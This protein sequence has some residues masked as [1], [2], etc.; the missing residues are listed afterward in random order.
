MKKSVKTWS[1]NGVVIAEL[2]EGKPE[3]C[4]RHDGSTYTAYRFHPGEDT[5]WHS[6]YYMAV[7]YD[8]HIEPHEDQKQT[9][10]ISFSAY[11]KDHEEAEEYL[12]THEYYRNVHATLS[13]SECVA[14]ADA[15]HWRR[16][17]RGR[18][19]IIKPKSRARLMRIGKKYQSR[20]YQNRRANRYI[21]GCVYYLI[22]D[23]DLVDGI[24]MQDLLHLNRLKYI[25][26]WLMDVAKYDKY[27][28]MADLKADAIKRRLSASEALYSITNHPHPAVQ[29]VL[30]FRLERIKPELIEQL[31]AEASERRK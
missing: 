21:V 16:P 1:K 13:L 15:W 12:R 2:F 24:T 28:D 29:E 26:S 19:G 6:K 25:D 14:K 30:P 10:R 7:Y 4:K 31:L 8:E 5:G 18:P 27:P 17:S 3:Q 22:Q 9:D 20:D 23:D 11:V